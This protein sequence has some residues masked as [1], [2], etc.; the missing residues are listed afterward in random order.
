MSSELSYYLMVMIGLFFFFGGSFMTKSMVSLVPLTAGD[1]EQFIRD[2]QWAFQY[3][4]MLEFG[5]RSNH[6]E[7]SDEIFSR[8][9]IEQSLDDPSNEAYRVMVGGR[10]V[11]GVVLS[12]DGETNHNSLDLF[13]IDPKE[14][15]KGIGYAAWQVVESL[16]P[17]T[18]V[19]EIITPY[20]EKRNIHFH[21]NKNFFIL[22]SSIMHIIQTHIC[23]WM[24][25]TIPAQ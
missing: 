4:A 11:G 1:R 15:G 8:S 22:W 9:T 17:E 7:E 18:K 5:E 20:F 2:N 24:N 16:Y 19:W 10:K 6:F 14:H 12:I 21:V 13:F 23:Q 25:V 3:G